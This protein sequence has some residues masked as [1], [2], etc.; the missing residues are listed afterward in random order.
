MGDLGLVRNYYVTAGAALC[1]PVDRQSRRHS[2]M[3]QAVSRTDDE[4]EVA[5]LIGSERNPSGWLSG[6][7]ATVGLEP[8]PPPPPPTGIFGWL[9][10]HLPGLSYQQRLIGFLVCMGFGVLLSLNSITSVT[11]A[12]L[13]N[14]I[15]FAMKYTGGRCHT[16]ARTAPARHLT[17]TFL[18]PPLLASVG[19]LMSLGSYCFLVGPER[20]CS[21]MFAPERRRSTLAYLGSL[22]GTLICVFYIR[23]L[24]LLSHID[25]HS[26]VWVL[27]D[28]SRHSNRPPQVESNCS[29]RSPAAKITRP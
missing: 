23:S 13:G 9:T 7:K 16:R 21:G 2:S 29:V 5:P 18:E 6:L 1:V 20:Q 11:E 28:V 17:P 25:G 4:E 27:G 10:A 15:P 26:W 22:V 14:P 3:G 24:S 8:P 12:L 19:N